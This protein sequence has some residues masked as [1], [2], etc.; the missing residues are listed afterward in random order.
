MAQGG[1]VAIPVNGIAKDINWEAAEYEKILRFRD[2]VL[3]GTHPRVKVPAHLVGKL[4][5]SPR[6]VSSPSNSTQRSAVAT[7]TTTQQAQSTLSGSDPSRESAHNQ[8]NSAADTRQ[9]SS[10]RSA[11]ILPNV[12]KSTTE[13]DPIFLSKSEE[14]VKAEIQLQRQRIERN[15]RE[16]IEQKK[17]AVKLAAQTADSLPDFDLA[18]VLAQAFQR[19]QPAEGADVNISTHRTAS[20]SDSFDENTFY[21][22]QHDTPDN[23]SSASQDHRAPSEVEMH[24]TVMVDQPSSLAHNGSA[25]PSVMSNISAQKQPEHASTTVTNPDHSHSYRSG[26]Q[27]NYNPRGNQPPVSTVGEKFDEPLVLEDASTSAK[28]SSNTSPAHNSN[29]PAQ[30]STDSNPILQ[31]SRRRSLNNTVREPI[32]DP[33]HRA[34]H[35]LSPIAPQPARVHSLLN[36]EDS[37]A[38]QQPFRERTQPASAAALQPTSAVSSPDGGKGGSR[39]KEKKKK[40]KA[41]RKVHSKRAASPVPYIKPEPRSPSPFEPLSRP[42]KRQR[43]SFQ[44][45]D[46]LDYDEPRRELREEPPVV[47]YDDNLAPPPRARSRSGYEIEPRSYS[48]RPIR[49]ERDDVDYRRIASVQHARRPLSPAQYAL[50]YSPTEI[51]PT[52]VIS[53][54]AAFERPIREPIRYYREEQIPRREV[55]DLDRERS[56]SPVFR[57]RRSPIPMALPRLA[58]EL[59]MASPR[60]IPERVVVDA[61]GRR[62]YAPAPVAEERYYPAAPPASARYSVAPSARPR[63]VLRYSVAPPARGAEHEVIY[64]RAPMRPPPEVIT[65]DY[66]DRRVVYRRPG[67][68][69]F[70]VPQVRRVIQQ[71]EREGTVDLRAYREREYSTR[72]ATM[73]PPEEYIQIRGAAPERRQMT[74]YAEPPR[75]YVS[76]ASMHPEPI[77]YEI[78]REYVGRLQSVRP[79]ALGREFAPPLRTDPRREMVRETSVRPGEPG[80]VRREMIREASVRPGEPG[81]IR[82]EYAAPPV[83]GERYE[84]SRPIRRIVE[85]P[86]YIDGPREGGPQD[87]LPDDYRREVYR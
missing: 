54:Q 43:Q 56:R 48:P 69:Q 40:D 39:R 17:I 20:E 28:D 13:L 81:L 5:A 15:L 19:I 60:P 57:E 83:D 58:Q 7:T 9:N 65:D 22:S 75:E 18:E 6:T 11:A 1:G 78:P 3:S 45:A 14:L 61:H 52:R 80:V 2:Q 71:P 24:D 62:Y 31:H 35:D 82:R 63:E 51:R 76:R 86:I 12:S 25:Y 26:G 53:S 66:E 23:R 85:E 55:V 33:V 44:N 42:L 8:K 68:P 79:E 67:S 36:V 4:N 32:P 64:E 37:S 74:H 41:P 27:P 73:A 16:Q 10:S 84:F 59:P 46:G 47:S 72:P 30:D 34:T 29:D 21:S 50:P 49:R 38:N 70:A 87:A 77:R